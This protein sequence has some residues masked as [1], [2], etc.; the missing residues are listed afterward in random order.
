MPEA[1]GEA[2]ALLTDERQYLEGSSWLEAVSAASPYVSLRLVEKAI[3]CPQHRLV[4]SDIVPSLIIS[5]R[6]S[7]RAGMRCNAAALKFCTRI[8]LFGN[9]ISDNG[10]QQNN[11][12]V[13]MPSCRIPAIAGTSEI[14]IAGIK[15]AFACA[16]KVC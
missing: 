14:M 12:C 15:V 7:R 3:A 13:A 16:E 11:R 10:G 6:R 5:H 4:F 2:C 1:E 8:K 9:N